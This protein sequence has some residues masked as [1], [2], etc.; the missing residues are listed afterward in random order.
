L[1]RIVAFSPGCAR[2][3][4]LAALNAV[5][6]RWPI[7]SARANRIVGHIF[8]IYLSLSLQFGGTSR[9]VRRAGVS[10]NMIPRFGEFEAGISSRALHRNWERSPVARSAVAKADSA[11]ES[12]MRA[13]YLRRSLYE[14]FIQSGHGSEAPELTARATES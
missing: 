2:S 10:D 14:L 1:R 13:V 5:A 3:Y 4:R 6:I 8:M 11:V 12:L 9:A 7:S